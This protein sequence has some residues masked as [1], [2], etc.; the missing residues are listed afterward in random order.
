MRGQFSY[1]NVS[2]WS[3]SGACFLRHK[4]DDRLVFFSC[5]SRTSL[6]LSMNSSFFLRLAFDELHRHFYVCTCRGEKFARLLLPITDC[7]FFTLSR[8][9]RRSKFLLFHLILSLVLRVDIL[10][11]LMIRCVLATFMGI[12]YT[13]RINIEL[14]Q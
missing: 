7:W 1:V 13:A 9:C 5:S 2:F 12:C 11:R 6:S 10:R 14:M 4:F 8:I 3:Q